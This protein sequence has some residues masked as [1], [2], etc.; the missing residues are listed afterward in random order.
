M[1]STWLDL[2][3]RSSWMSLMVD[4]ILR[5]TVVLVASGAIA[6]TLRRSSAA[7]R[8]LAW[9]VGLGGSLVLP[10]LAMALPEWSWRV[11][12][13]V[14][15]VGPMRPTAAAPAGRAG[16]SDSFNAFTPDDDPF[17]AIGPAGP[18]SRPAGGPG[19]AS[20]SATGRGLLVPSWS[21]LWALWAG[22]CLAVL[23]GPIAGGIMLRRWARRAGPIDSADWA[24]LRDELTAT[25]GLRRRVVLL[26]DRF[27]TMPMTWGWLRPVVLLP[28]EA[29]EWSSARR[30]DVLLHELA[31]VRRLD[32][33]T[34]AMATI[35]CAVYWFHPLAWLASRRMR[36]ERERACD[37][38]V[39]LAGSRASDYAG[40]LLEIARGLRAPG[41][42]SMAALAMARA[43]QLEGRLLAILDPDRSRRGLSRR[44][45]RGVLVGAVLI[46]LP[47]AVVRVGARAGE[48]ARPVT[49]V[50]ERPLGERMTVVGRVLDPTGRPV[51]GAA[52]MVLVLEK[53]PTDRAAIEQLNARSTTTAY[54]GRCD[55][56]G[57]FRVEVPRTSSARHD[58][59]TVTAM[60]P[61]FGLGWATF[62]ADADPPT[63]DVSLTP[64]QVVRGRL[65]DTKGLPAPGVAVRIWLVGRFEMR[66][67]VEML[68]RPDT[69]EPAWRDHAAWPGP[70]TS[71]DQGH[72]LVR[73]LGRGVVARPIVDD[74][75]FTLPMTFIQTPAIEGDARA[76]VF[77]S[78]IQVQPGPDARPI[79]IALQPAHTVT[80]RVTYADTGRP[81]PH[82][83][84][85]GLTRTRRADAEGRF[86][87]DVDIQGVRGVGSYAL[88]IH[89]REA[90]PYMMARRIET[91]PAGAVEQSIDI[92][93]N[94]GVVVHGR[95]TEEG[96]GRPVAGAIVR[97]ALTSASRSLN[98]DGT[99]VATGPDGTYRIAG[100]PGPAFVI[101]QG[102]S[103]D[104]VLRVYGGEGG[105]IRAQAG[106]RSRFYAHAY[107][108]LEL[109]AGA[110]QEV[111]LTV[112]RGSSVVVRVVD[113]EGK[114][115]RGAAVFSRLLVRGLQIGGWKRWLSPGVG[116]WAN[117]RDGRIVLHG[118]DPNPEPGPDAAVSAFF[119]DAERDLGAEVQLSGR[120]AAG[121]VV[122]RL[123]PC[124]AVQARLVDAGGKPLVGYPG[125]SIISLVITPGPLGPDRNAK[126]GPLFADDS[127]TQMLDLHQVH[128]GPGFQTDGQGRIKYL[129][130]I[131]GAVYRAVDVTPLQVD[132]KA[133]LLREF[134]VGPGE[135]LDLGDLR[136]ARPRPLN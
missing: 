113:P 100:P 2:L 125:Y 25:L 97:L 52:V 119:L 79:K 98:D 39:L 35:A 88:L 131:P 24:A 55:G 15:V 17:L 11:L 122:V 132:G 61:G 116:G 105:P 87:I 38:I 111:N 124:G 96:T 107:R 126:E 10:V 31:H 89:P 57:T 103:D 51:P 74:P 23:A 81:V 108:T 50:D 60:A 101:V 120:P 78:T 65:F 110:D 59:L 41:A 37:D 6:I 117:V 33:L 130:L 133:V 102:P 90:A 135:T 73:G 53:Y 48:A 27:A 3:T 4:L 104:S 43:S 32:G 42:A 92:A 40:H 7:A 58:E 128:H 45:V 115:A 94:R 123:Q 114:P 21:W 1:T 5:A 18:S 26:R 70:V 64:E 22:G 36:V 80:G 9:C 112:R 91:W 44:A 46:L 72:F 30:R 71:D 84:I 12:P 16:G 8:H 118:I 54:D 66:G 109:K 63:V 82:A 76:A 34:Q 99:A 56:S 86:R 136:V 127:P 47:L 83:M 20:P 69:T 77:P 67:R 85:G 93:L 75:R 49:A 19:P 134:T 62:D 121:G 106:G 13:K 129:G 14:D 29:D 95:I 28:A 68:T